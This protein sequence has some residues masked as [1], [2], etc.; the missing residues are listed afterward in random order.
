[1]LMIFSS[2]QGIIDLAIQLHAE[3]VV[4]EQEYDGGR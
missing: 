2:E 1:M 4:F 3:W